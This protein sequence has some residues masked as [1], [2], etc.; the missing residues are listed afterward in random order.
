MSFFTALLIPFFLSLPSFSQPA[1][2]DRVS[3]DR[4][5]TPKKNS[6]EDIFIWK[7]SDELNLSAT[8]E[9]KFADIHRELNKQKMQLAAQMQQISFKSKEY[10]QLSKSK[11]IE[12]IKEYKKTLMAYNN[13]SVQELEKMKALLGDKKYLDYL[14]I[15]QD[16][17]LRLKSLV[18]GNDKNEDSKTKPLK[19]PPPQ[20]IE[21]K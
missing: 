5:P 6:V 14:A 15:K 19:L 17:N 21:E 16:I 10:P 11:A 8:E 20:I 3:A 4:A 12:I 7:V 2:A 13:L 1:S 9:K 18:L